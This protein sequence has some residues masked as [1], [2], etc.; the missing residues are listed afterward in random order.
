M[1][2]CSER[3]IVT[4]RVRRTLSTAFAVAAV[5]LCIA[6]VIFSAQNNH[7]QD[8]ERIR[9][10]VLNSQNHEPIPRALVT[11]Q[12]NTYATMTDDRGRFE[13]L[14]PAPE[15]PAKVSVPPTANG[16]QNPQPQITNRP[17]MLTA[18]KVGFLSLQTAN[19]FLPP[20]DQAPQD[21]VLSLTPEARIIGHLN[22]PSPDSFEAIQ[23]ALY[24][25]DLQVGRE[26]WNPAGNAVLRADGQFRFA[27]LAPGSY[28]LYTLE[29]LDRDPLTFNPRGPM[30]GYPPLYYPSA[31]DFETAATIK[32]A[33]G[34]TFEPTMSPIRKPYYP[35]KIG[36]T[37]PPDNPQVAVNVWP[38]GHSGPGYELGYN[39]RDGQI[40]G[41]LPDGVYIVHVTNY[42][43]SRLSGTSTITVSGAPS[44]GQTI[45]LL[46]GASITLNVRDEFQHQDASPPPPNGPTGSFTSG[47]VI[48]TYPSSAPALKPSS[49][50][51]VNLIPEDEFAAPAYPQR[52]KPSGPDDESIVMDNV[53]PGRYRV[54]VSTALGYV[55]SVTC[56]GIDL[57]SQPLVVGFGASIP[58][59]EV[60]L[61]DDGAEIDG[62]LGASPTALGPSSYA[63]P[64]PSSGVVYLI[65]VDR[66]G[67][68]SKVVWVNADRTFTFG[69][70]APGNYRA[71]A[72]DHPHD[73]LNF[74]S[75]EVLAKYSS[76]SESITVTP[77]Q[78]LTV[79]LQIISS[80]E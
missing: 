32:L 25:R 7:P 49:Y 74:P 38:Q 23:V 73:E 60:T 21:L 75:E 57:L 67:D 20:T 36:F 33:P 68:P 31:S 64:S 48:R 78:K 27:E 55:A 58:T 3:P 11:S 10:V 6:L 76:Q 56:G 8:S 50:V 70:L 9:G 42:G 79:H 2:A 62:T 66:R 43:P 46:P 24:R 34:Q 59:M 47:G 61:R 51:Q 26:H 52:R 54:N 18:R 65:A 37:S 12:D 53:Q 35:V 30:F 15:P 71:L 69:M 80:A 1:R 39:S 4:I 28:K 45:A 13:F 29:H 63:Y 77:G 22:I 16:F 41:S 5:H 40:E 72:A 44:Q 17:N 14:I 19:V